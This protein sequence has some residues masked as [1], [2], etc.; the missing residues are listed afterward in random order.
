LIPGAEEA[1]RRLRAAGFRLVLMTNQAGVA[2][3]LL[4]EEDV[5]RVN[6]RLQA[7]LT[8]AGVPLDAVYYCPHHPEAG[9]PAYRRE[10]LCRKPGP[11][12][13][14]QAADDLGLD[15]AR[16]VVIGDH[17]SDVG[18]ARH[19]PGMRAIL[20]LTG[21]GAGQQEKLQAGEGPR[22]DRVATDLAAAVSWVLSDVEQRNEHASPSA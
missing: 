10:C 12:M 20:V 11:G 22:P 13:A 17:L 19:F 2:R 8:Q 21:H 14:R 5:R 18:V 1:L 15:A 4:T 7:L 9:P 3:G 16:S 6:E